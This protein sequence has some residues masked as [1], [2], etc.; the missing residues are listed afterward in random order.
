MYKVGIK[1]EVIVRVDE[2]MCIDFLGSDARVLSTPSMVNVIEMVCRDMVKPY[3][4]AD[5]DTVGVMVNVKHIAPTPVGMD[6]RI[7]ATLV[8]VDGK[9][10]EFKAEVYD[11]VEKVGEATHERYIINK[12]S[13]TKK[14]KGK[15]LNKE[16]NK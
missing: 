12:A 14:I 9:R 1:Q 13:F 16:N 6:I 10:L 5:H 8:K 11:D 15:L 2:Q 7:I 3:L 4:D